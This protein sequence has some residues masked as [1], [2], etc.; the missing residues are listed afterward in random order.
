MAASETPTREVRSSYNSTPTGP[1]TN[2]KR[3]GSCTP[4]TNNPKKKTKSES[5]SMEVLLTMVGRIA[6]AREAEVVQ[7]MELDHEVGARTR[8]EHY[9][10]LDDIRKRISTIESEM[11][12]AASRSNFAYKGI[13]TFFLKSENVSWI[14]FDRKNSSLKATSDPRKDELR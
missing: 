10:M 12:S 2:K 1:G 4:H 9:K 14:V 8:A 3:A 11:S 7:A 5:G 13:W 6:A